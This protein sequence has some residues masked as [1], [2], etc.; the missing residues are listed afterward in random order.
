MI[1][2]ITYNPAFGQP[3][4]SPFCVKAMWLLNLS[5]QP[6]QREDTA[7]P[8][9]MPKGKLPV[10]RVGNRL[11]A[12]S[13]NIRAYLEEQG[14]DFD[15]G[16]SKMDRA[17]SRA[18]IRMAEEHLYF[19][20]VLDRWGDDRV[21]PTVRDTYFALIPKPLRGLVTNR[22]RRSVI[23]GA[24]FQGLG[25]LSPA[26]RLERVEP[27]LAAITTRLWQGKFLFGDRPTAADASVAAM[28]AAMRA[29]PGDTLLRQRISDDEML[30]AYIDRAEA[31]MG[32][33]V[34]D[35]NVKLCA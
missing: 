14:T 10:I 33:P 19:H 22:L 7:D 26:E 6:W 13:D 34:N 8:R 2:L 1:T 23:A 16:L 17:T 5:G 12:D 21:W 35:E 18:F 15:H 29:T 9:K 4:G 25:R 20:I 32:T 24:N 31:T 30:T 28:L 11:I 27:D 3:A